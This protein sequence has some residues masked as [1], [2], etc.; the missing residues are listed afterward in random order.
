MKKYYDHSYVC[1]DK[2]T[3]RQLYD[4]VA[5]GNLEAVKN[6][7][8]KYSFSDIVYSS[9]INAAALYGR[10]SIINFILSEK[11]SIIINEI[12]INNS[13]KV[14]LL[15]T[16]KILVKHNEEQGTAY[17]YFEGFKQ[18]C[19]KGHNNIVEYIIDNQLTDI[20]QNDEEALCLACEKGHLAI[21][22]LLVKNGANIHIGLYTPYSTAIDNDQF[23]IAEYIRGLKAKTKI[24]YE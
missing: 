3:T 10:N 23:K 9:M 5:D 22:K 16:F 15:E 17:N 7:H 4:Y 20:H 24:Y 11:K 21:V 12:H 2:Q 19:K 8:T 1:M 14:G 6:M 18:A 13:I